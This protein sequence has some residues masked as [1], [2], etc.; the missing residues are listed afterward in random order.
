MHSSLKG[1]SLNLLLRN[2]FSGVFFL[3]AIYRGGII[4]SGDLTLT[5]WTL[6]ALVAGTMVYAIHRTL[7]NPWIEMLRYSSIGTKVL[8]S[9]RFSSWFLSEDA[10][11]LLVDRWDHTLHQEV[12]NEF[13][14]LHTNNPARYRGLSSW[15]DYIHLFYCS[16]LSIILGS[17][18]NFFASNKVCFDIWQFT[19]ALAFLILGLLSDFRRQYVESRCIKKPDRLILPPNETNKN[20]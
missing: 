6:L 3:G 1:I 4:S 15:S 12:D 5:G 20:G 11:D 18:V 9:N 16:G 8:K 17:I 13:K 10:I 19:I 14:E 7:L 2:F